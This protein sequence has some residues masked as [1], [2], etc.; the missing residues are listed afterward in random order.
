W[1]TFS[2]RDYAMAVCNLTG[3]K[4]VSLLRHA[5]LNSA[6]AFIR[7]V[8]NHPFLPHLNRMSPG[9]VVAVLDYLKF[10]YN[11]SRN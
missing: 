7:Y 11:A 10:E 1:R 9:N 3:N 5:T 4:K 2:T 8:H 6:T